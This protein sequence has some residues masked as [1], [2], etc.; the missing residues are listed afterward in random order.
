MYSFK[1]SPENN[2][3]KYYF[4]NFSIDYNAVMNKL[5]LS[6]EIKNLLN[7]TEFINSSVTDYYTQINRVRLLKRYFIFSVNYRF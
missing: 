1:Q 6:F 2:C 5:D 7:T 4:S 3:Q